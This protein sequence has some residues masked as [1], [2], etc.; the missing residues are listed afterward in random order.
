LTNVSSNYFFPLFPP[1]PEERDHF[2]VRQRNRL[3]PFEAPPSNMPL[4][5][6]SPTPFKLSDGRWL[7]DLPV[8]C[9]M[10]RGFFESRGSVPTGGRGKEAV[11]VARMMGSDE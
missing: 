4:P 11:E 10:L 5:P 9:Q 3:P 7:D 1:K 6:V 8:S 2:F